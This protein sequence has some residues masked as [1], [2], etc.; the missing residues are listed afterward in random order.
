MITAV[1][2]DDERNALEMLE[3]QLHTYCP[4]V[5]IMALCNNADEG[6]AA[7]AQHNPNLIFLDIEM[8]RKNGFDFIAAY[9]HPAFD[10]IFTTAYNQFAVKAFKFSAL[11]YLLKPIIA[12]ELVAAVQRHQEKNGPHLL[13]AQ[14]EILL[15][16]Y[17]QPQHKPVK[18][19]FATQEEIVLLPPEVI[20]RCESSDN[21]STLYL[22]DGRKILLSKTL[23][24]IEEVLQPFGFFRS[25]HSH[26]VSFAQVARYVKADGGYLELTDGSQVPVSRHRKE[27]VMAVLL[28]K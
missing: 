23:K 26:L 19:P 6:M 13:Q 5:E 8:P 18:L 24:D 15:Q 27:E 11:D 21:Y 2:I 16:Q 25:H 3:W 22:T 4:A 28:R 1:L 17:R 12:A 10:V 9:P 7:V 14:L 20:V